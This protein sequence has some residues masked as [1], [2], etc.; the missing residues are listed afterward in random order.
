MKCSD[1]LI[2]LF[3]VNGDPVCVNENLAI[4]VG[5]LIFLLVMGLVNKWEK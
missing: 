5:F 1:G 2:N 4:F 3:Q